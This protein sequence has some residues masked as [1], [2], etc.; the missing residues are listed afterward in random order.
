MTFY[1]KKSRIEKLE[2][3]A[4]KLPDPEGDKKAAEEA[5][6]AWKFL[7]GLIGRR[8]AV[9]DGL[10]VDGPK[11]K[12]KPMTSAE[13]E[14]VDQGALK[15]QKERAGNPPISEVDKTFALLDDLILRPTR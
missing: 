14:K 3:I 6:E 4:P 1:S 10:T 7:D 12:P 2:Q 8:I 5:D 13:I 15:R 9:R 11:I